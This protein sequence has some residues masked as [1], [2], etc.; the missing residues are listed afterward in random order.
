MS[1]FRLEP[2]ALACALLS[3]GAALAEDAPAVPASVASCVSCHSADGNPL[4]AGVP[5]LA[6]QRQD[7]LESALKSY[8]SGYRSG[9]MA[10]V[11]QIFA[12]PLTDKEIEEIATWFSAN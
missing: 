8:R 1:P 7:Y 4:V 12:K 10:D 6:G 9:G 2:I 11:M 3:P 5:I